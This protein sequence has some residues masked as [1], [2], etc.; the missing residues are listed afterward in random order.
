[1]CCILVINVN[2]SNCSRL[3]SCWNVGV[4]FSQHHW[5]TLEAVWATTDFK[6][7]SITGCCCH[8]LKVTAPKKLCVAA[9]KRALCL[10][11]RSCNG[12]SVGD[13]CSRTCLQILQQTFLSAEESTSSFAGH[14]WGGC[15]FVMKSIAELCK[16]IRCF[17]KV[18][19][20]WYNN[21]IIII[22]FVA[23][24]TAILAV[25]SILVKLQI[26]CVCSISCVLLSDRNWESG[27]LVAHSYR[28]RFQK[29]RLNV[30]STW[31]DDCYVLGFAH[32]PQFLWRK[33][34]ADSSKVLWLRL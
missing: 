20:M 28:T 1:M 25:L 7:A 22:Y 32:A 18:L 33:I 14:F 26:I 5:Q 30:V 31:I 9:R 2:C 34:I 24:A 23:A 19:W 15:W 12:A 16:N 10:I 29:S 21:N 13:L 4:F 3:A 6:M 17:C 27:E 11:L 8:G